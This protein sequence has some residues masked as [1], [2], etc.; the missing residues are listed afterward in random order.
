MTGRMARF[1]I[2]PQPVP[3]HRLLRIMQLTTR[4]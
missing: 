1:E 4:P 3:A 2:T